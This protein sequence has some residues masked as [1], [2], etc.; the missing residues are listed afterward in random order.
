MP[1]FRKIFFLN[2]L[3]TFFV[4]L[5]FVSHTIKGQKVFSAY[6]LYFDHQ[7]NL[8]NLFNPAYDHEKKSFLQIGYNDFNPLTNTIASYYVNGGIAWGGDSA[9]TRHRASAFVIND[10]EGVYLI[11]LKAM[12]QYSYRVELAPGLFWSNGISLGLVNNAL[13]PN[14][15]VASESSMA[16][17]ADLGSYLHYKGMRLGLAANQLFNNQIPFLDGR[18]ER[19]RYFSASAGIK[20]RINALAMLHMEF[21]ARS[22]KEAYDKYSLSALLQ[23]QHYLRTGIAIKSANSVVPMIGF[24]NIPIFNDVLGLLFSYSIPTSRI[25]LAGSGNFEMQIEYKFK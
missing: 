19:K 23:I 15:V 11:R 3:I 18:F 9:N 12:A 13:K 20:T 25:K 22:G 17:D 2:R 14:A 7:I 4:F 6:P 24:D 8:G 1:T 21:F 10:K 5:S 16:P